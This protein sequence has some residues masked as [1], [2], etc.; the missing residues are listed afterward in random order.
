MTIQDIPSLRERNIAL[1]GFMGVGKTSVGERIAKRLYRDFID[2]DHEIEKK[3]GMKVP[4]IFSKFGEAKFREMEREVT[5]DYITTKRLKII[6]LGGGAYTQPEIREACLNYCI[7]IT[8]DLSWESWKD[9]LNL[10]IDSRPVLHNKSLDE[11]EDLYLKRQRIYKQNSFQVNTDHLNEAEV[12]E[13]I[14]NLL[15]LGW[16]IYEPRK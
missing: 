9:R 11:I 10:I 14:V 8:L 16:D 4:D 15:H 7:V 12:A 13:E 6:S 1:I 2:M 3:Y 5:I